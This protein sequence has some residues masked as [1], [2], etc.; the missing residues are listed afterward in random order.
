MS[1]PPPF[2]NKEP[3]NTT[4]TYASITQPSWFFNRH[5]PP[6]RSAMSSLHH[7]AIFPR[8]FLSGSAPK[9]ILSTDWVRPGIPWSD[10]QACQPI[11]RAWGTPP[12]ASFWQE[13]IRTGSKPSHQVQF[14]SPWTYA[15]HPSPRQVATPPPS[16]APQPPECR[17]GSQ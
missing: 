7:P 1:F 11:A 13:S 8:V 12:W 5:F 17:S 6:P 4:K 10:C 9:A 3:S 2:K 14:P 15:L 16:S